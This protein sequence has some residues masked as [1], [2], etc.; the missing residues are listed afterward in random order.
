M[1]N[2]PNDQSNKNYG[3]EIDL[4]E[5]FHVLW[6]KKF[7]IVAITSIFALSSILYALSLPNIYKSEAIM[8]PVEANS[9]MGG[10]LGQY[11]GMASL[12]GISIP[13]G[14]HSL[15]METV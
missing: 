15:L 7:Y 11:S 1:N 2:L 5:L 3:D 6:G 13:S 9:E 4:L 10:M 14:M 12:A 8:M